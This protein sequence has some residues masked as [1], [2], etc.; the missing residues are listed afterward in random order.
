[1]GGKALGLGIIPTALQ[2]LGMGWGEDSAPGANRDST[3]GRTSSTSPARSE[4]DVP[5]SEHHGVAEA[6]GAGFMEPLLAAVAL[7]HLQVPPGE[8]EEAGDG[9][10]SVWQPLPWPPPRHRPPSQGEKVKVVTCIFHSH[11]GGCL[12]Q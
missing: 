1:M 7:Q 2:G 11:T 10:S 5:V 6:L 3:A 4:R 9:E 8:G 12:W